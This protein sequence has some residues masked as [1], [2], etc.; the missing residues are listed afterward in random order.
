MST[1]KNLDISIPGQPLLTLSMK[2]DI[3]LFLQN[4]LLHDEL[5]DLYPIMWLVGT[6][7]SSHVSRLHEQR[8]RGRDIVVTEDPGLHLLWYYDR[9]FIKPLPLYLTSYAFWKHFLCDA[10]SS[11]LRKAALG[12]IRSYAFLIKSFSDAEVARE[13]KLIPQ[14]VD[15][16][17]LLHFLDRFRKGVQDE[18][19]THRYKYGELRLSRLNTYTRLYK[20]KL[21]YRKTYWQYGDLLPPLLAPFVFI[22]ALVSVALSAMQVVLA[23]RQN[24]GDNRAWQVFTSV[25]QWFSILCLLLTLACVLLVILVVLVLLLRE[26]VYAMGKGKRNK[27]T[28]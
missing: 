7:K 18:E 14:D 10:D 26:L 27:A 21:Y 5:N 24:E 22:F 17:A 2:N 1:S 9:V 13:K 16:V 3:K 19:T 4:D 11:E 23:V 6:Q 8:V 28:A 12:L 15:I 25:S 20:C